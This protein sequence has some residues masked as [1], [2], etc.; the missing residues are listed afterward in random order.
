MK[1]LRRILVLSVLVLFTGVP[2]AAQQYRVVGY[3]PAWRSSIYPPAK[4]QMNTLTHIIHAFAWPDTNGAINGYSNVPDANLIT[5]VHNAG[6]KILLALGGYGNSAG[7]AKVATTPQVRRA[8]V[9]NVLYHISI[10]GYDGV[11]LDWE[12]PETNA[13]RDSLVVLVREIRA[14]LDLA[15]SSLSITMAVPV[16][17]WSGQWLKFDALLP[18]VD[19]FNAMTYDFHGS[20]TNHA[21]HNAPLYAPPTDYDGS[22][23]EG[24][25][26]LNGTRGIPKGQLVLGLAFFGMRFAASGLYAPSGTSGQEIIYSDVY[27]ATQSSAWTYYWDDVSKVPYVIDA[28]KTTVMAYDDSTSIAIKCQYAKDNGLSGVMIWALGEDL[29]PQGQPLMEAVGLAMKTTTR[30]YAMGP[31]SSIDGFALYDNYPNPFNPTTAISFQLPAHRIVT[32]K[33]FD[34]F[35]R[36][37]ATLVNEFKEA[38]VWFVRFDA[39]AYGLSSGV[40]FYRIEAGAFTQTKKLILVK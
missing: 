31:N 6:K 8:F 40:Y 22:V 39:S 5:T 3:Y 17:N 27:T 10:N 32:L 29:T 2:L 19:W 38:G 36:E 20:W 24:I 16:S 34:L 15:D 37:V 11:D 33:V 7:F 13:Q 14:A 18:Y 30:V 12:W 35:G 9:D 4:L 28:A 21:G 26:Y 25:Q 23:N 1:T